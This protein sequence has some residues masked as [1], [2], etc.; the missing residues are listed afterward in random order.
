MSD[1]GFASQPLEHL[2]DSLIF[3]SPSDP[4]CFVHISE[5]QTVPDPHSHLVSRT[6][7]HSYEASKFRSRVRLFSKSFR[8][9]RA[10]GFARSTDLI[11]QSMLFN[12]R[13]FE[14][15]AM[16]IQRNPIG[17]LEHLQAFKRNRTASFRCTG[18]DL[19]HLTSVLRVPSFG[20]W[21]EPRYIF[22]AGILV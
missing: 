12:V 4:C 18:S 11:R 19:C 10:D 15:R 16:N 22:G 21:L 20:S 17:S 9:I 13:K 2:G 14:T 6:Q 1:D 3:V 7:R 5:V 8:Q